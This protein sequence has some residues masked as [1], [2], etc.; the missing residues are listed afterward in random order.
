MQ[1]TSL[2]YPLVGCKRDID[3]GEKAFFLSTYRLYVATGTACRVVAWA[4]FSA[5]AAAI[6]LSLLGFRLPDW[7]SFGM[8][9]ILTGLYACLIG[10]RAWPHDKL[11]RKDRRAGFFELYADG[12]HQF[13]RCPH[14]GL[15]L[16]TDGKVSKSVEWVPSVVD[17]LPQPDDR[18]PFRVRTL[19]VPDNAV[20]FRQMNAA[21][22]RQMRGLVRCGIL[23]WVVFLAL[24]AMLIV[25]SF[26]ELALYGT[27]F[28][29]TLPILFAL[30]LIVG[31]PKAYWE[32]FSLF[33]LMRDVRRK[34]LATV[35]VQ[36]ADVTADL[37][38]LP[39]S[40]YVWSVNASPAPWRLLRTDFK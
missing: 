36:H 37:E 21:E 17:C 6:S 1:Q 30:W 34:M 3:S 4:S 13:V 39:F 40:H 32:A 18:F 20:Q 15:I 5:F 38:V 26:S 12:A 9:G 11:L 31:M 33:G 7:A 29:F 28:S 2:G 14:S 23:M 35:R 24:Q 10:L 8:L 27:G 22:V 19:E 25:L 16:S